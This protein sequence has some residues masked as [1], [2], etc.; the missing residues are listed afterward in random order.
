MAPVY[1]LEENYSCNQNTVLLRLN[2]GLAF[3][4]EFAFDKQDRFQLVLNSLPDKYAEFLFEYYGQDWTTQIHLNCQ[5][6]MQG[7]SKER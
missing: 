3:D 2:S 4:K 6:I 5:T 1:M 7:R